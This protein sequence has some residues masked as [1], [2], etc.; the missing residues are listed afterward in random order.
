M[1]PQQ[2]KNA[3]ISKF[4]ELD[5]NGRVWKDIVYTQL[6]QEFK[7]E[8]HPLDTLLHSY[9][10]DFNK[11]SI[12]FEQADT[13][14][15]KLYRQGYQLGLI[16]NGRSPFQEHNFYALGLKE[17]FS[18]LV[19]SEAVG[20]RKPDPEIFKYACRQLNCTTSDCI[21]IGDDPIADIEGAQ[22]VGM[23]TILFHPTLTSSN[24]VADAIIHHYDEL[25]RAI[26]QLENRHIN[27]PKQL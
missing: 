19:I 26:Q 8:K 7:I 22:R 25:E 11:F 20:I 14:I 5:N 10:N 9:I 13:T 24:T 2:S 27:V 4:I 1:V 21:F 15:L 18:I 17:Y 16:S 6:I 23:Q 3:F 12:A